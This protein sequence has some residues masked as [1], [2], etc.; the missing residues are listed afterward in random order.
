[1]HHP[2]ETRRGTHFHGPYV[3]VSQNVLLQQSAD[4]VQAEPAG[5]HGG[6]VAALH[7]Y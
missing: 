2:P 5:C 4:V 6:G 7:W 3:F 1:M